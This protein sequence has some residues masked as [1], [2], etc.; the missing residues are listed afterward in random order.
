MDHD[1]TGWDIHHGESTEWMPWGGDG[2]TARAK[3][4]GSGD[5]YLLVLVEAKAGYTGAA[6]EHTA[7]EVSYVIAGT[8]ETQGVTMQAGDGYVAS[9]GSVHTSFTAVTDATYVVAFK[10]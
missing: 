6:H 9:A 1:L 10:L 4:L 8:V 7:A 5:G 2:A 3:V